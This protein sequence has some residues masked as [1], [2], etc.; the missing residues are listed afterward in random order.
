MY[1]TVNSLPGIRHDK[2]H[3]GKLFFLW[4]ALCFSGFVSPL[5]AC[6]MSAM[7]SVQG[8]TLD[9]F[10][11]VGNPSEYWGYNDPW[12]YFG[13]VMANSNEYSNTDGYGV[14]AYRNNCAQLEARNMWYKRVTGPANFGMVWYTGHFL[15][16]NYHTTDWNHDILDNALFSSMEGNDSPAIVMCH[17]RNATGVTYG[18]HP[19]WFQRQRRTFTFMHNGYTSISRGYMISRVNEMN[20]Q[21]NWWVAHPNNYFGNTDPTQW[22]DTEVF[23]HYVMNFVIAADDNV[24]QGVIDAL[25]DLR[26]YLSTHSNGVYNFIMSDGSKLYVFRSTPQTG[27]YSSYKLSYRAFPGKFYGIRTQTPGEEDIEL[28]QMELVVFSRDDKPRHYTDFNSRTLSDSSPGEQEEVARQ[29]PRDVVP[30]ASVNPNPVKA[31]D[32]KIIL[33]TE[34]P[35]DYWFKPCTAEIFNIRG[36][37]VLASEWTVSQPITERLILIPGLADGVY[38]C[39]IRSGNYQNIIRFSVAQ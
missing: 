34:F 33:R 5:S 29:K 15:D 10:P 9:D 37:K 21:L 23:F 6:A 25:A 36:Q 4:V 11:L 30:S 26:H 16:Y 1:K 20:P 14:V 38:L 2:W 12:D 3:L 27:T 19:F 32:G 24:L 31:L 7:I 18:N 28:K 22:V 13:F 35:E 17:A 8:S 39:R